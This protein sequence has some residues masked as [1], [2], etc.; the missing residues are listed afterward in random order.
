MTLDAEDFIRNFLLH[1]LADGVMRVRHFGF[2]ANR[3][4]KHARPHCRK[5]LGLNPALPEIPKRSAQDLLLELT[6]LDLSRF[7]RGQNGMMI[8]VGE[9]P[10]IS[11]LRPVGVLM[12]K[13]HSLL[14]PFRSQPA[15]VARCACP[16]PGRLVRLREQLA[17][18]PHCPVVIT[19]NLSASIS[20]FTHLSI[21]R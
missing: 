6:G 13:T 4:K 19:E 15:L 5:L 7:P 11:T 16:R 1:V 20:T 10:Q 17:P 14:R 21:Y 9:L 18:K 2:L 8:L 12:K 3:T